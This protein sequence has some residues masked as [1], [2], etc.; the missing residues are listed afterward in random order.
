M[1]K[2]YLITAL[3]LA[4]LLVG[5]RSSP[6]AAPTPTARTPSPA[7]IQQSLNGGVAA[8]GVI[9]PKRQAS[10][11]TELGGIVSTVLAEPGQE[12]AV[13]AVLVRLDTADLEVALAKAR[14][15]VV[16]Q[17]AI[18]DQL[19]EGASEQVV[20]RAER[21]HAY[22]VLQAR[23]ALQASEQELEQAR[24]RDLAQDVAAAQARVRQ[25][26][27]QLSR[28][29]AQDLAPEVVVAQ[30]GLERAKIALDDAQDEYNKALDRPWEDQKIRDGW[31]RQLQQAK[32]NYRSAQ[33]QVERAQNAQRAHTVGLAVLAAQSDE[34]KIALAQAVDAQEAYSITLEALATGIETARANLDHLVGWENPYLDKPSAS[35]IA[36]AQARLEQAQLSLAQIERQ[37]DAA[38]V[39]AP[40]AGT[41][42]QVHA[43]V[44]RFVAPGQALV[45]LGD[46]D[47]LRAE[48]TDLSERDVS[49]VVVGQPATVYVEALGVEVGG[50]VVGISPEATTVGGD[51]VFKVVIELD[52]RPAGLRWGMSVEVEIEAR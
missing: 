16:L 15:G 50:H 2:R 38:Q 37:I 19:V 21:D 31:A 32:L 11:S 20:A 35:E 1:T 23:L 52:E 3:I 33:A 6:T 7:A 42:S 9:A 13:G 48:T 22:Q 43:Q 41:V 17:Q 24:A 26:E 45:D 36:Q 4:A 8:S 39:R 46:L 25:L 34:A 28:A 29:R 51:V 5:C 18:L 30:L 12:V 47:T 44:G 14:Q 27:L 49:R 10:V 40:F